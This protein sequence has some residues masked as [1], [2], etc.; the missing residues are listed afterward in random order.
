MDGEFIK[1]QNGNTIAEYN[2]EGFDKRDKNTFPNLLWWLNYSIFGWIWVWF[3]NRKELPIHRLNK[4][5]FYKKYNLK[6]K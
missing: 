4:E 1:L 5:K 2:Y 6:D 3:L